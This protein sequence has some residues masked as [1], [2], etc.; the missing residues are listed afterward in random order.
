MTQDTKRTGLYVRVSTESQET[1]S[2]VETCTAYALR[3]NLP[4]ITT[5]HDSISGSVPWG[6]REIAALIMPD[7][8]LTDL[9][10][11]EFSRIGRDMVDTLGFLKTCNQRNITVHVV[12]NGIVVRADIGG[13][14]LSTVMSLAAEIERDLLRSRTKDAL[15]SRRLA[16]SEHGFFTSKAGNRV[17]KLGRPKGATSDSKIAEHENEIKKLIEAKVADAAIARMV[18][19]DPRTVKKFR[20]GLE[21]SK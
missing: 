19:C 10:V 11:Y 21:K 3:E 13:K 4:I 1:K 14:V 12:K 18:K 6:D 20:Q 16:I 5:I 9:I 2:Q 8:G 7:I 15:A 17:E